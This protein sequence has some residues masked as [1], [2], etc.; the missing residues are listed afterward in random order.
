MELLEGG[1][2]RRDNVLR[3]AFL[4]RVEQG[5]PATPVTRGPLHQRSFPSF[6]PSAQQPET[7]T[8]DHQLRS[9]LTHTTL[10]ICR[11][12]LGTPFAQLCENGSGQPLGEWPLYPTIGGT[13]GPGS[14]VLPDWRVRIRGRTGH[15]ALAF[16]REDGR[17]M[18]WLRGVLGTKTPV[19]QL[20]ISS[21]FDK[22]GCLEFRARRSPDWVVIP[23]DAGVTL[24]PLLD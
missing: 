7:W 18:R 24:P 11:S 1:H 17:V 4:R 5:S 21:S 19:P 15:L 14:L 3:G 8:V 10:R 16:Y 6:I 13:N 23:R 22:R 2:E 12:G 20:V 9:S